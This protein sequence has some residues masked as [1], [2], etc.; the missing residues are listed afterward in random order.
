MKRAGPTF[1]TWMIGRVVHP[2][3]SRRC[4]ACG[5]PTDGTGEIRVLPVLVLCAACRRA[6]LLE[7][8]RDPGGK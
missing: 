2:V 5:R 7:S 4:D 8:L 6:R 1:L 3:S